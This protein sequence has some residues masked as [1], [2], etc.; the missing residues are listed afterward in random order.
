MLRLRLE[1]AKPGMKL[2]MPVT[3]PARPATI[4]LKA[5]VILQ[6]RTIERLR[7]ICAGELWIDHP[8]VSELGVHL[9]PAS[10]RAQTRV[11]AT[12]IEAI[13]G[14]LSGCDGRLDYLRYRSSIRGLVRALLNAP[15]SIVFVQEIIRAGR[16][17][18]AHA[19]N[20][21]VL[22]IMMGMRLADRLAADRPRLKA[23]YA[24]DVTNLG[25]GGMFHDIGMLRL[26][27]LVLDRWRHDRN[28]YDPAWRAHATIGWDLVREK[29]GA[30][31]AAAVLHHH[32]HFDGSGFPSIADRNG[33]KRAVVGEDIHVF[34]RI[35]AAADTLDAL[36]FPIHET[37]GLPE[38]DDEELPVETATIPTVRALNQMRQPPY[39]D[40]LDPM[41]FRALI[42]IA[43]PYAPG[44][45]VTLS[46]GE[47]AVVTNWTAIDPCRPMVQTID[48]DDIEGSLME[49]RTY[50]L[51]MDHALTVV[52]A[53]GFDVAQDNFYPQEPDAD[54]AETPTNQHEAS[55]DRRAG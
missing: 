12:V 42:A 36:R 3:H 29:I 13:D 10:L 41:V 45:I 23:W 17:A 20:V 46:N 24:Q 40:R 52:R 26:D 27:A 5:G 49:S 37:P 53:E 14:A 19:T 43:P 39:C 15:S 22:S 18:L 8:A 38:D 48:L 54:H 7:E 50:A 31:G 35:V 33:A 44:T 2:A 34:G 16:P 51:A 32:Q 11:A 6:E 21:C 1:N 25:L 30:A 55:P 28:E 4:L 47:D 9:N